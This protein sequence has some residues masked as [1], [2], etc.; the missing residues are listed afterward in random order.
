MTGIELT[1]LIIFTAYLLDLIAGDPEWLPHP[2]R[3]IGALIS[4]LEEIIRKP[5]DT[6]GE[7]RVKGAFLA[8]FVALS[9]FMFCYV[10]LEAAFQYSKALYFISSVYIVWTCIAVKSLG[11]EASSI[12]EALK[13]GGITAARKRLSRVVGR[14]TENLSEGEVLR[15]ATETV[16]ENTSDGIVAPL[17]YLAVGGPPLMMAYKAVN[18]L[19]S[20]VGYKNE[21][22]IN[23]G[24]FSARLDDAAN[25]IPARLASVIMV[26]ASFILGYNW[27][28][29]YSIV[30]R[31]GG[32]H[33]SPNSGFPEAAVAGALGVRL[34]GP[35]AYG[36]KVSGKPFIGDNGGTIGT[37][38]LQASIRIM[39]LT[40]A[41]MA[42]LTAAL[43]AL[44]SLLL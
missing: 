2:V 11:D 20:M 36:G 5:M 18:T 23:F 25:Y 33:P 28:G 37:G 21:R 14:D 13:T 24:R 29:A 32:N 27:K 1:V 10:L 15:A 42:A 7:E 40:S 17:F 31:D 6:H 4:K 19:D 12:L 9:V 3:W 44:I 26:M 34:G 35:S 43:A 41:L 16:A 8:V 30:L 22:Y 38:T 39:R